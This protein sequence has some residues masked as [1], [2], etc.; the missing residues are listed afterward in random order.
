MGN[1]DWSKEVSKIHKYLSSISF[2]DQQGVDVGVEEGF[3]RWR[4]L[5]AEVRRSKK[6]CYFI[7][8]G[9]SASI[10]SHMAA[11]LAKNA[12]VHTQVF[13][14]LAL[15]TAMANDISYDEVYS[16]PLRRRGER[17]DMLIGISS[18]GRSENILKAVRTA[19]LLGMSVI[20]L[21]SLSSDNPL[22]SAG[23]LNLYVPARDYGHAETCHAAALH[24]WMDLM[25][26]SNHMDPLEIDMALENVAPA[27]R[28]L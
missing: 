28:E 18:S 9:A 22:R 10:A 20:T 27:K 16:E 5:T 15:I 23:T 14:D 3:S 17:G 2:R 19:K 25:H 21:S 13:S 24:Y 12:F 7:G 4:A 8:N 6:V 1:I 11:D 26:V